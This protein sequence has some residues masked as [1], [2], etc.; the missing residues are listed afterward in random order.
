[1][2][3]RLRGA[4][5]DDAGFT[6]IELLIVIIILAVLAAI[7]VFSVSG[8]TNNS[9]TSACKSDVKTIDTAA[10]A[11]YA[12]NNAASASLSALVPTFLHTDTAIGKMGTNDS[13]TALTG[14]ALTN[15]KG[16][17]GYTVLFVPA[18]TAYPANGA[19]GSWNLPSGAVGGTT[20]A[21]GAG[22]VVSDLSGC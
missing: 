20:K 6:L 21:T 11:Y 5:R 22:D 1:M 17:N 15:A 14:T 19:S 10:E 18:G 3:N 8:I 2:L 16:G 7:V 12:Q 9:T 4:Q 13:T